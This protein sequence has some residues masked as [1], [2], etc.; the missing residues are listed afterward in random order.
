MVVQKLLDKE[1]NTADLT[2]FT[3]G[4]Q[5]NLIGTFNVV[6][7]AAAAMAKNTADNNEDKGVIINTASIAAFDGQVGQGSYSLPS[8][9]L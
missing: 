2:T 9:L 4:I 7:L 5:I 8:L 3:R 6:R 1:G